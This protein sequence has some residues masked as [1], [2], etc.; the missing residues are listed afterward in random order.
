MAPMTLFLQQMH[1]Q[2][3]ARERYPLPPRE[4]V[5]ELTE[6]AGKDRNLRETVARFAGGSSL[7]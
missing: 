7:D 6:Q 3:P 2:L 1:Q 4:I 5:E